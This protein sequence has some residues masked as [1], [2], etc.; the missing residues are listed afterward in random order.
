MPIPAVFLDE[1]RARIPVSVVVGRRIKLTKA[2][3]EW[4]GLSPFNKER[5]PS[6]FVNDQKGFYHDFSSGKHGDIFAFVMETEGVGFRQA[7]EQIAAMAGAAM[8]DDETPTPTP[9]RAPLAASHRRDDD[10]RGLRI[11]NEA[12]DLGRTVSAE[13]LASR[14]LVLAEGMSGRV[15]R[16]HPRCPWRN[17]ADELVHVPA[18]IALFR[19]VRTDEPTAILRRA[20]TADGRKIGKPRYLGPMAGCAIKLTEDEDICQGLHVGEGVE[21]M[22]A[23]MMLGF[24]PA[25]ATGGTGNLKNFPVLGGIDALTIIVDHDANGAGQAAASECFDRWTEA[26]REVWNVLPNGVGVD[27][28]DI[29]A[30]DK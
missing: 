6:F 3:R 20:L 21:T 10:G 14:K 23:A 8:L 29:V 18:L 4:K 24:A 27:M 30:G 13:Y 25:W 12:G 22:L 16:H 11:W 7:V 1:L 17:D 26:G 28:N 2:G 15:L 5:S 19:D 9:D